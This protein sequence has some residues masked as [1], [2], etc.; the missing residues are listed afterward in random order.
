M[1]NPSSSDSK[2][3]K[4]S[5]VLAQYDVHYLANARRICLAG[6]LQNG[7]CATAKRWKYLK[8]KVIYWEIMGE[9]TI[10]NQASRSHDP[11]ARWFDR[12]SNFLQVWPITKQCAYL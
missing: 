1:P 3:S 9:N 10:G 4:T 7:D 5:T 11:S 8:S 12:V 6:K 2:Q